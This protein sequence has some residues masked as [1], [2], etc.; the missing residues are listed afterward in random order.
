MEGEGVEDLGWVLVRKISVGE[1][2]GYPD[3]DSSPFALVFL[4]Q[5]Y[6]FGSF[7]NGRYDNVHW[8]GVVIPNLKSGEFYSLRHVR[9]L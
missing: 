5:G 7:G 1:A 3:V 9:F 8:S 4:H 2:E 6:K